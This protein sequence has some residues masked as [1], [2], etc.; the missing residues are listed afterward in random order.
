M[1][2]DRKMVSLFFEI[3]R[4]L[5]RSIRENLKISAQDVGFKLV[6]I[7]SLSSDNRLKNLIERF[8]QLAGDEWMGRIKPLKKS[9]AAN[10]LYKKKIGEHILN[11]HN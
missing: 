10:Y 4:S 9:I 5:P 1:I 2:I 11:H 8:L 7:H 6:K 3:K